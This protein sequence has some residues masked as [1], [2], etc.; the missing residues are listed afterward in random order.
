[1]EYLL[2]LNPRDDAIQWTHYSEKGLSPFFLKGAGS[3]TLSYYVWCGSISH[4]ERPYRVQFIESL[5][6]GA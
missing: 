6:R 5:Q 3:G 1:M 2:E 4:K